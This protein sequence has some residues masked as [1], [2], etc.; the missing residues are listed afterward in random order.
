MP[1]VYL[2]TGANRGIGF[3]TAK[4][5]S[6]D[7][8][9]LVIATTRE[10]SRAKQLTDLNRDNI[11]VITLDVTSPL[12]AIKKDVEVLDK[13]APN[14]VDVVLQN[15]GVYFINEGTLATVPI[16]NYAD[17]LTIN[18][19]GTIKV[20]QALFPYWSK[21]HEGV[22]KKFVFVSSVAAQMKENPFI[23]FGYG[24]SKAAINN[25][26]T[27]VAM[28]NSRSSDPTLNTSI[29]TTV[30]PGL[31]LTDMGDAV[32]GGLGVRDG[33]MPPEEC[34]AYLAKLLVELGPED[35]GKFLRWDGE[36]MDW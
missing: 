34:G 8:N 33:V 5:L 29:A 27:E 1:T 23:T 2:I 9:N 20:Y 11:R 30:H 18:T 12:E 6:E 35:N 25:F 24:V 31:V 17:H 21:K 26:T 10:A 14:G 36:P 7:K 4:K 16:S 32:L 15:A 13:I 3:E 19:L 22:T 28:E